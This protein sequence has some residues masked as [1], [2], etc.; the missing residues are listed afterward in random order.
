MFSNTF[1]CHLI[2]LFTKLSKFVVAKMWLKL[3]CF[4]FG[5]RNSVMECSLA[6][7]DAS[8]ILNGSDDDVMHFANLALGLYPSSNV[9]YL[10]T[11]R[12]LALLPSSGKKGGKR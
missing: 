8:F 10:K 11:F 9:F 6:D 3:E 7:K 12:K 2:N 1:L 4:Q 5:T